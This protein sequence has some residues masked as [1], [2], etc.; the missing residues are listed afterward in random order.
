M[1]RAR[2]LLTVFDSQMR[3][4]NG[5]THECVPRPFLQA[6]HDSTEED[7]RAG[8]LKFVFVRSHHTSFDN[9]SLR[10]AIA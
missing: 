3:T 8:D 6:L 7:F 4:L 10:P 9:P 1:T 5:T 2:D